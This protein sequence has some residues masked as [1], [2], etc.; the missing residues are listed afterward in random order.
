M[1]VALVQRGAPLEI[2][3]NLHSKRK[4]EQM[5]L[6]DA[7]TR[8]YGADANSL[9][10]RKPTKTPLG[11]SV[12]LGRDVDHPSS[13]VMSERYYPI[14]PHYNSTRSGV[15][16]TVDGE[17]FT[18]EELVAMVLSH[19]RDI[20]KAFGVDGTITDC[21]LTVPS[22]YTQHERSALLDAASLADLNVLALIDENTAAGLHYG[23]DRIDDEPVNVLFYNMGASA[24]QVSIMQFHSYEKKE[25]YSKSRKVGSFQVLAKAWDASLGGAA[26]D[27]RIVDFMATEFNEQWNTKRNDGE[28]KDVRKYPRPMAKLRIQANKVKHVLS[29]NSDFPIF[30]DALYDDT[31][32]QSHLSRG[33]FEELCHDLLKRSTVPIEEALKAANMTLDDIHGVEMIG[34]GMRVPKVQEEIKESLGGKLDLGMHINSDES[35]ALGAAFHGANVSTAFKVRHVGM[36]DINPFPIAVSLEDLDSEAAAAAAAAVEGEEEE[37]WSKE[38]TIFKTNGKVGVKKTIAFTHDQE[39]ACALDYVDG[40][41]IPS[42]TSPSIERYNVTG[43]VEFAKEMEEKGLSK[44]KISLQFELS[45]SGIVKLIKAEGA[46][47]ETY[48]VMEEEEVDDDEDEEDEDEKKYEESKDSDEEDKKDEAEATEASEEAKEASEEV[49]DAKDD[50]GDAAEETKEEGSKGDEKEEEATA[51][52]TED[53]DKKAEPEK[54]KKKKKMITVEKE[55]KKTHKRALTVSSYHVGTIQPYSDEIME[56]SKAKLGELARLDK[57]RM[58][59]EEVR[60]NYESYIYLIKNKLIDE[61]EAIGAVTSEEQRDEL[62]K[63]AEVAEDWMYDDGYDASLETYKEKYDELTKPAEKVFFRVKEVTARV[64]A[65]SALKE[66]LDKVVALMNKWETTMPQ[67]TEDERNDVVSKVNNVRK[68]ISEK[69]EAQAANDPTTDPVFTS[70]EVPLQT[71]DI[72]ARVSKLSRRPKPVPKKE[73]KKNETETSEK[74]KDDAKDSESDDKKEEGDSEEEEGEENEET[75]SVEEETEKSSSEEKEDEKSNEEAEEEAAEDEL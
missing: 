33:K 73:E 51:E 12:F 45:S 22:F 50:T 1:K 59:L 29:A 62:R 17:P 56:E 64:E 60:N 69:E 25:K 35:M 71:K 26:F 46:V 36:S 31:N 37:V 23:I 40:E 11:M 9:V 21:V 38:A 39:I 15:C 32:Y 6:F 44:P 30:I 67:I 47:E 41:S 3:T 65:I 43:I 20:T 19:A 53:K 14:T 61:E 63:S 18:P 48:T 27:A 72:Q 70:A 4:T 8:F 55:K 13:K 10:A 24:L 74:E 7:G 58:M 52:S 34:G 16:L 66:K 57:E 54:K 49:N 68:W 42:G 75:D 28:E 5:V 2:V